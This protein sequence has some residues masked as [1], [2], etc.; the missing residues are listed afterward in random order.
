VRRSWRSATSIGHSGTHASSPAVTPRLREERVAGA[1]PSSD[2]EKRVCCTGGASPW[3]SPAP[4]RQN[5]AT[6]PEGWWK[7]SAASHELNCVVVDHL[8]IGSQERERRLG[9]LCPGAGR[10]RPRTGITSDPPADCTSGNS[11]EPVAR[12]VKQTYAVHLPRATTPAGEECRT[13]W[14]C[15]TSRC[16]L[17]RGRRAWGAGRVW[18]SRDVPTSPY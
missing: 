9:A 15:R 17:G 2:P 10:Q 1:Q 3:S 18:A 14:H 4:A 11:R 13:S 5:A 12:A 16:T 7:S 6:R 8:P